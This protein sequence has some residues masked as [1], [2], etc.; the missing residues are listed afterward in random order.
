MAFNHALHSKCDESVPLFLLLFL[1]FLY[2]FFFYFISAAQ[3]ARAQLLR[4]CA[5]SVFT[6]E[7]YPHDDGENLSFSLSFCWFSFHSCA[8]RAVCVPSFC[9]CVLL[10]VLFK[11]SVFF[12]VSYFLICFSVLLIW[13]RHR[14]RDAFTADVNHLFYF[15]ADFGEVRWKYKTKYLIRKMCLRFFLASKT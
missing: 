13:Q 7:S 5:S 1:H 3:C 10:A 11:Y 6:Y 2:Y 8:C 14:M 4:L 9:I 15:D 12:S